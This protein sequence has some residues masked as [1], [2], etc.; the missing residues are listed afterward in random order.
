MLVFSY[1]FTETTINQIAPIMITTLTVKTTFPQKISK[2]AT[3]TTTRIIT[4]PYN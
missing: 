3:N 1:Q 2:T 4:V